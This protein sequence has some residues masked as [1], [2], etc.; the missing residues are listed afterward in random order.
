M[1]EFGNEE[2]N[3]QKRN[4]ENLVSNG[5]KK[6][7]TDD[8]PSPT[9]FNNQQQQQQQQNNYFKNENTQKITQPE[10]LSLTPDTSTKKDN[11]LSLFDEEK[12]ITTPFNTSTKS[13]ISTT[14]NETFGLS[15][16]TKFSFFSTTIWE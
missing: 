14:F 15:K 16:S 12:K 10:L 6:N 11:I 7:S 1:I 3:N 13:F 4:L 5:F 9:N 2:E 8:F